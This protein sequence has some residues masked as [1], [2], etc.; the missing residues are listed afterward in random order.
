MTRV[1]IVADPGG[2][3]RWLAATA[4]EA[5]AGCEVDEAEGLRAGIALC[6]AR[7][8]DMALVDLGLSGGLGLEMVRNL[9]LLQPRA[10]CVA[11]AAPGDDALMVAALA[12]GAEGC[13]PIE[14]ARERPV[15]EL[16]D[17]FEGRAT[18]PP[19]V[20]RRI[21]EHFRCRGATGQVE[22]DLTAREAD[23]LSRIGQ[24]LC[25]ADVARDLGISEN[26]VAGD[27]REICRKLANGARGEEL[28]REFRPGL[29][30]G[31]PDE[32]GR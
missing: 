13:L 4:R 26:A 12:A 5:F 10:V 27:V 2:A 23:V 20:A 28:S 1:L 30:Q 29:L 18:L 7:D 15:G 17:I 21:E 22:A 24:G 25:R 8:H 6:V 16:C 32:R 14:P 3:G 9:R 11:A 19:S 31:G